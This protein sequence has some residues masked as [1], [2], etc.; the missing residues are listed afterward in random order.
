MY[1]IIII[2][3][4]ITEVIIKEITE[5]SKNGVLPGKATLNV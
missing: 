3:V 4:K 1:A 5:E 2:D